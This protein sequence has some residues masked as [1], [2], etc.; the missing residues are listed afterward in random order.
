[1]NG[2]MV[3]MVLL[4]AAIALSWPKFLAMFR[5]ETNPAATELAIIS[6]ASAACLGAS[7]LALQQYGAAAGAIICV[8]GLGAGQFLRKG[9]TVARLETTLSIACLAIFLAAKAPVL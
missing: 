9:A 7:G 2:N 6:A 8:V 4:V 5:I 3:P 1:M